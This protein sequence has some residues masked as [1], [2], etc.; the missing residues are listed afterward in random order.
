MRIPCPH[1]GERGNDEFLYVG[2]ADLVRPAAEAPAAA[3]HEYV[4]QRENPA[5]PHRELWQHVNGCR[6]WLV[7]TRDTRTHAIAS[8]KDAAGERA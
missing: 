2:A 4:Y 7:V 3:W 8:A 6:R 5:G 1:C